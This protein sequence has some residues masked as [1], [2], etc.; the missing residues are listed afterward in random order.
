MS[1]LTTRCCSDLL[2]VTVAKSVA[3]LICCIGR[4]IILS[5]FSVCAFRRLFW[6]TDRPCKH[7]G[8][9]RKTW[10]RPIFLLCSELQELQTQ[11]AILFHFARTDLS[12]R[13]TRDWGLLTCGIYWRSIYLVFTVMSYKNYSM[14][15]WS[16]AVFLEEKLLD[17]LW[18]IPHAPLDIL[19]K[20]KEGYPFL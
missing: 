10:R 14:Y 7:T 2:D 11:F 17:K 19:G 20:V 18:E 9:S 5:G 8:P 12:V 1:Y 15:K 6:M 16:G 4:T 3:V 13:F